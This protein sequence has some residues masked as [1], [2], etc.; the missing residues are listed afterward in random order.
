MTNK[1]SF[2]DSI[3]TEELLNSE[4][5]PFAKKSKKSKPVQIRE[6]QYKQLKEIAFKEEKTIIEVV[7]DIL[8]K[9]FNS[10]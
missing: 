6:Y 1:K 5:S 8:N 9:H 4:T 3:D 7:E 2:L 10:K